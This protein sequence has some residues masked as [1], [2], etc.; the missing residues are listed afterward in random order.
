MKKIVFASAVVLFTAM[1]SCNNEADP[2]KVELTPQQKADSLQK[3][4][5]EEH[6]VAMPKWMKIPNVQKETKRLIDSIGSLPAKAQEAAA[7]YKAKLEDSYKELGDA[8]TSMEKWMNEFEVQF[9]SSKN[10]IEQRIKY[11]RD[12]N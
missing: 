7:P 9:D 1:T 8:Y 11:L 4:V 3:E 6:D 5:V 12:E 2:G 10:N